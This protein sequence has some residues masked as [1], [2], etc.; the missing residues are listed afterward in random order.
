[1]Q[2][3]HLAH[4]HG[5]EEGWGWAWE[6]APCQGAITALCPQLR[7]KLGLQ[8]W[9]DFLQYLQMPLPPEGEVSVLGALKVSDCQTTAGR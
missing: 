8:I 2:N 1:M 9:G 5:A 4:G 3:L 7:S 6:E